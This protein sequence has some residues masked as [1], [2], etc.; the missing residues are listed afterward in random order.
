MPEIVG[1][2]DGGSAVIHNRQH[3]P[4]DVGV[5]I[6]RVS[7]NES[8]P[9]YLA[10]FCQPESKKYVMDRFMEHMDVS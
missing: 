2:Y 9:V 4:V 10:A 1:V 6:L 7:E 8:A 3:L 5:I